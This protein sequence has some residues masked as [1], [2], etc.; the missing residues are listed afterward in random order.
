MPLKKN[1]G[2][3]VDNPVPFPQTPQPP[4]DPRVVF[5]QALYAATPR[6]YFSW[7]IM[8]ANLAYFAF[9]CIQGVDFLNPD[10]DHLIQWGA[11]HSFRT[12]S[13]Q[14]WRLV[15]SAFMHAGIIHLAVNMWALF[16]FGPLTERLFGNFHFFVLYMGCAVISGLASLRFDVNVAVVGASGA[17]FGLFGAMLGF[18]AFQRKS[19]PP[20]IAKSIATPTLIFIGYNVAIGLSNKGISNSA[21][22]GG[23][24]SGLIL[25]AVMARPLAVNRR[26]P[27][28][29]PRM[30]AGI[31]MIAAMAAGAIYTMP[32]FED[33]E[34]IHALAER[35]DADH[36]EV[37]AAYN[38]LA[39]QFNEKKISVDAFV[40]GV[41][42]KVIP[43]IEETA[44]WVSLAEP[45][46]SASTKRMRNLMLQYCKERKDGF[47][48]YAANF[49]DGD[50]KEAARG[51]ELFSGAMDRLNAA[52]KSESQNATHNG[53]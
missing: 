11:D 33:A 41:N 45:N 49:R 30:I 18:L 32:K 42:Q 26:R 9:M 43:K 4:L 40:K 25:G 51:F 28:R 29:L 16:N 44:R 31:V 46:E 48:L 52:I 24:I 14:W 27:Q 3:C 34:K 22:I 39:D 12:T 38:A 35:F 17:I 19:I 23:L 5:G 47:E 7:L 10:P 15:T 37:E 53:Q 50:E 21:H 1:P 8:A 36:A 6:V 20:T 2:A 13:G